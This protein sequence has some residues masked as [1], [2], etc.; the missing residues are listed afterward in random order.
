MKDD[1]TMARLP[2]LES[3]RASTACKIG[4]IADLIHYRSR[5]E[6]LIER[7]AERAARHAAPAR[8]A[9]SST[10][11]SCPTRRISR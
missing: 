1:G 3:S 9:W 6:R 11:T 4:T 10:A 8:S 2:D 5:T 7:V